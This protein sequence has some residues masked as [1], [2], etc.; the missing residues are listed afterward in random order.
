MHQAESAEAG[1]ESAEL[2]RA[3]GDLWNVASVLGFTAIALVDVGRFA[4][5]LASKPNSSPWPN[6][7]GIMGR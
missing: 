6:G 3:A 4:E 7:S 2:L 1:L 5:A